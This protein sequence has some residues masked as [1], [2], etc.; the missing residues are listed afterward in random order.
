MIATAVLVAAMGTADWGT[1]V[2]WAR[3]NPPM[4]QSDVH[5]TRIG[6]LLARLTPPE[7]TIAVTAAGSIPYYARRETVDILGKNDAH[8]AHSKPKGPFVPGHNKWDYE[9]SIGKLRPDV[10][11][12]LWEDSP[13]PVQLARWGYV[14]NCLWVLRSGAADPNSV[15]EVCRIVRAADRGLVRRP[16]ARGSVRQPRPPRRARP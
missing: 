1:L 15:G 10:I 6:L 11:V 14:L 16:S 12:Q 7:A 5:W 13:A 8:V 4:L 3:S 2:G 9:Y